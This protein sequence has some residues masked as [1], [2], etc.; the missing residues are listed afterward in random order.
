M[1]NSPSSQNEVTRHPVELR[2]E[3]TLILRSDGPAHRWPGPAADWQHAKDELAPG[4]AAAYF[5]ARPINPVAAED[6]VRWIL[7]FLESHEASFRAALD[8]G[9]VATLTLVIPS[10]QVTPGQTLQL[11]SRDT[12][13]ALGRWPLNLGVF[14]E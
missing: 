2:V 13:T 6:F 9:W 5:H 4:P 14:F 3:A 8:D 12:A 7:A 1:S 11:L 10:E